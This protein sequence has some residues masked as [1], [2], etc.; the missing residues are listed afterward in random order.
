MK[1]KVVRSG[2]EMRPTSVVTFLAAPRGGGRRPTPAT[3]SVFT[4]HGGVQLG[5]TITDGASLQFTGCR[6]LRRSCSRP[7][8]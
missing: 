2:K 5:D 4:I 3:S 1:L 7:S 6:F 8:S